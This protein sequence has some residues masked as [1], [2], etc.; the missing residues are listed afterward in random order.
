MEDR[1]LCPSPSWS[2]TIQGT[3]SLPNLR[4]PSKDLSDR[5]RKG[6]VD[7]KESWQSSLQRSGTQEPLVSEGSPKT[8]ATDDEVH[9]LWSHKGDRCKESRIRT[10]SNTPVEILESHVNIRQTN[11]TLKNR[12]GQSRQRQVDRTSV[13]NNDDHFTNTPSNTLKYINVGP[14]DVKSFQ[15]LGPLNTVSV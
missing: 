15:I 3:L 8:V 5:E 10:E 9:L 4:N 2:R 12:N 7:L 11:K 14:Y 13:S 1:K 6:G